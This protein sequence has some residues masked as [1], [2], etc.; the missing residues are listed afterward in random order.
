MLVELIDQSSKSII[1]ELNG[2]IISLLKKLNR[3]C[4]SLDFEFRKEIESM[5]LELRL[6]FVILG[7]IFKFFF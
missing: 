5:E 6:K 7:S 3:I 4:S 1:S 2:L